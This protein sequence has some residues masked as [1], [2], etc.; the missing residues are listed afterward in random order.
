MQGFGG[1][2]WKKETTEHLGI[3]GRMVLKWILKKSSRRAWT[4]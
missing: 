2:A 1:E 3:D 4:A